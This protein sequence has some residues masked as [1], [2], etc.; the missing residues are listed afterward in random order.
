MFGINKS[1]VSW[2]SRAYKDIGIAVRKVCGGRHRKTIVLN[3]RYT[4]SRW[5]EPF[6]ITTWKE[7]LVKELSAEEALW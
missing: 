4:S 6:A 5:K 2:A 1:V 7:T 3:D